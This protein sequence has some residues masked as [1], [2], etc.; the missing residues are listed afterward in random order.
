MV[1]TTIA[2]VASAQYPNKPIKVINPYGVGGTG[3]IVARLIAQKLSEQSGHP[4]IVENRT[5]AGGRIGYGYVAK[6]DADGYTL[7][8]TEVSFVI[9]PNLYPDLPWGAKDLV[10]V[11]IYARN[12]F[13]LVVRADA[14]FK[15]LGELVEFAK[16]NPGKVTYGS[17]GMGSIN[18]MLGER[19]AREAKVELTHVPY[20]GAGEAFTGVL[21]GSIDMLLTSMPTVVGQVKSGQVNALAVTSNARSPALPSVPTATESGVPFV[22]SNWFGYTAPKGTS[23]EVVAWLH[24]QGLKVLAL[25]EVKDRLRAMGAEASGEGPEEFAATIQEDYKRWGELIRAA[26]IKVE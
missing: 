13:A 26:G 21:T 15:T 11:T 4:F 19:F 8:S 7:A 23:K 25:P 24:A 16:A 2:L 17:A 9:L 5:G 20:K 6:A 18:H 3:D 22:A 10:P 1:L 14:R 12:P